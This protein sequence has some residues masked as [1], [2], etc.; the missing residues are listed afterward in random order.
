MPHV[1]FGD[2]AVVRSRL[3]KGEQGVDETVDAM[4]EM[5]KGEYGARSAKIRALAINIVNGA[6]VGDKDY[7]GMIKAIHNWVRDEIRY[8][9]DPVGQETLSYPEETAFNSKAGDCDDKTILEIAILGSVGI[10]A[11]P[12]VIGVRPG[13]YSHVYLD[14]EVPAGGRP[15]TKAGEVVHADPIMREW[16]LGEEAPAHKI[17]QKKTYEH[18]AGFSGLSGHPMSL[19]AYATAPSYLDERNVSSVRPAMRSP[20]V[21]TASR[22]EILNAPKVEE[23]NTT[24]LDDM[25]QTVPTL[26]LHEAPW[27]RLGPDGPVTGAEAAGS[28]R[29][30]TSRKMEVAAPARRSF[31][32]VY[33]PVSDFHKRLPG[34]ASSGVMTS[35]G[36]DIDVDDEL[37]GIGTYIDSVMG[38][39]LGGAPAQ[40][41][42]AVVGTVIANRA[43]VRAAGFLPGMGDLDG[44]RVRGMGRAQRLVAAQPR[45]IRAAAARILRDLDARAPTAVRRP[46]YQQMNLAAAAVSIDSGLA[47]NISR[48]RRDPFASIRAAMV[49]AAE[50]AKSKKSK[51]AKAKAKAAKPYSGAATAFFSKSAVAA[52]VAALKTNALAG[53][54]AA[55]Q[56]I[57]LQL[58]D[59]T[60]AKVPY[61]LS[62]NGQAVFNGSLNKVDV[63][64]VQQIMPAWAAA[65]RAKVPDIS[66]G[67][68]A[69]G[70]ISTL[71]VSTLPT[72]DPNV[73][74]NTGLPY[75][76]QPQYGGGY[77]GQAPMQQDYYGNQTGSPYA[78]PPVDSFGPS[79][80]GP[81]QAQSFTKTVESSS[82]EDEAAEGT[83]P[84][85]S[86]DI[87]DDDD[88]APAPRASRRRAAPAP[89][90]EEDEDEGWTYEAEVDDEA[91][92]GAAASV[93][94]P[95]SD[96]SGDAAGA[97]IFSLST[98]AVAGVIAYIAF[99]K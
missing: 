75:G 1:A 58:G 39:L 96:L 18:L 26:A 12:V 42:A 66:A 22:G 92:E 64:T 70:A 36:A 3:S 67:V 48:G 82:W 41:V 55:S 29:M 51:K 30:L 79:D 14:I 44:V 59:T 45:P 15:G 73:D 60:A 95:N 65:Q 57:G 50:K 40:K 87:V 91:P 35:H 16:E 52:V 38:D 10:R 61:T 20:L 77:T 94:G 88:Q 7:W 56:D 28:V 33:K 11:W 8:V 54:P 84:P 43:A 85:Q 9:K 17:T 80:M 69:T 27:E 68:S 62:V 46:F 99:K 31:K 90:Y 19:G 98:L 23:K 81:A 6:G 34:E 5:A 47:G 4:M 37:F 13:H 97:S 25:F 21:D 89:A 71:P 93:K 74:P 2:I 76:Q 53:T 86:P 24:E 72:T 32:T 83:A 78:A 49:A 63:G